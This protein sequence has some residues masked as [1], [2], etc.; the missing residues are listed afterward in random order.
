MQYGQS[1]DDG[2]STQG[3]IPRLLGLYIFLFAIFFLKIFF[4][5]LFLFFQILKYSQESLIISDI[6]VQDVLYKTFLRCLSDVF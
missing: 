4:Q 5:F 2:G 1:I 3:L 6:C